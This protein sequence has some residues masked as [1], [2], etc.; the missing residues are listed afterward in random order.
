MRRRIPSTAA[1]SAF[2]AA[3]RHES[4]TRAAEELHMT[5]SAVCRHIAALESS[6]G[7]ELFRRTRRGVKLTAAGQAYARRVAE[8]LAALERDTLELM[9]TRGQGGV[10]D[11]AVVPTFATHWLLPRLPL[12]Q[13]EHPHIQI[14]LHTRVRPFL[15]EGSGMDLALYA[16][17]GHWP[18]CD[19]RLLMPERLIAVCAPSLIAPRRRLTPAQLATLPL[20]Q[21][22]TRPE[23]WRRWFA[24][25]GVDTERSLQG[26]RYELFSMS[27]QAALLGL[28][29]ALV[30]DFAA[31]A[32]LAAGRLIEP[33]TSPCESDRAYYLVLPQAQPASEAVRVF[34]DWV[35]RQ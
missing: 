1:L 22:T 26:P 24:A 34:A 2:E 31:Q 4:F 23:A 21:Q 17:D 33:A 29:V 6:L 10:I 20:L 12:F 19:T 13:R 30:P 25:A 7:V 15:F 16:G 14:H 9:S 11:L 3:A 32:E 27:V 5:Q 8:R 35:L 18:G 28:G